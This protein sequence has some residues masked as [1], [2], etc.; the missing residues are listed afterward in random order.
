[1]VSVLTRV[2]LITT[3][4]LYEKYSNYQMPRIRM[5]GFRGGRL[6][7]FRMPDGFKMKDGGITIRVGPDGVKVEESESDQDE[8]KQQDDKQ[9]DDKQQD[10]D[11]DQ[12]KNDR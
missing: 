1:M 10:E 5:D 4:K 7:G 6:P 11:S 9:Q 3:Q 8:D 2:P 12:Q